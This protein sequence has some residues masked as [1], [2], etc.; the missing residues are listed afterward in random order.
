MQEHKF[1]NFVEL[2]FVAFDVWLFPRAS[3]MDNSCLL[4]RFVDCFSSIY[5]MLHVI[6]LVLFCKIL[7][8]F[9]LSCC[10]FFLKANVLKLIICL[11]VCY[12]EGVCR[13]WN[14]I[15]AKSLYKGQR[16]LFTKKL[17]LFQHGR[18][19]QHMVSFSKHDWW[20]D[21]WGSCLHEVWT[22]KFYAR[23]CE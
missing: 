17:A 12:D 3:L 22:Q 2:S 7:N 4:W 21:H 6:L 1:I 10:T 14:E 16:D 23:W 20:K 19:M 8:D 15:W 9:Y 18:V 13:L 11:C 5:S